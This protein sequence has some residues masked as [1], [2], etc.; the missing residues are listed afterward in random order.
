MPIISPDIGAFYL[1]DDIP[2]LTD[3]PN[4]SLL[5]GVTFS[6]SG[7]G[8]DRTVSESEFQYQG[9]TLVNN[10]GFGVNVFDEDSEQFESFDSWV[11]HNQADG[12]PGTQLNVIGINQA[13]VIFT[14]TG[15]TTSLVNMWIVQLTD[16]TTFMVPDHPSTGGPQD[17]QNA[18]G[19][20]PIGNFEITS[21]EIVGV[22]TQTD[23]FTPPK[24]TYINNGL[25]GAPPDGV[26]DGE[27][28]A[29]DMNLGYDDS[30]GPTDGGGDQIT[31]GDDTIEGNGGNDTINGSSGNDLISGGDDND[32]IIGGD[33]NDTL[34]GDAG[35][36]TL[37]GSDGDDEINGGIGDDLLRPGSGSDTVNGGAGNDTL[38]LSSND[39]MDGGDDIDTLDAT[40]GNFGE[41]VSFNPDDSGL[42]DNGTTFQNIEV[43][44]SDGGSDNYDASA[45]TGDLTISTGADNDTIVGGQ[46]N[47]T[48][49]GGAD[50]DNIDGGAG[51]DVVYGGSGNDTLSSDGENDSLFGGDDAD[52]FIGTGF[53]PTSVGSFAVDGGSGGNDNDTLD[54]SGYEAQGFFVSDLVQNPETNGNP[55]FDGAVTLTNPTT[56]EV[57]VINFTDIENLILPPN[58]PDGIVDGEETGEVMDVGYDDSNGPNDDGGDLI[59]NGADIIEGNGG[60]DT[61]TAGGGNDT[62]DGGADDDSIDGGLGDDSLLGGSGSDTLTG[63]A[64]QDDLLGDAGDDDIAVGG[65]DTGIGGSGDDVFTIDATDTEPDVDITIDGGTDGT[66]G[67]PDDTANGD[68]G[69][70]LDL[71]DQTDDLDVV[72]D[73]DPES[74]TVD[75]LDADGTPDIKFDEIEKILTGSGADTVDGGTST[76][77]IDVDTG[78]GDD[79]VTGGSGGDTIAAGTGD[80]VVDGGAGDDDITGGAGTDTLTGGLGA[81]TLDGGGDDDDLITGV[82]DTALGGDGDDV[83]TFDPTLDEGPGVITVFG[84]EGDEGGTDTSNDNYPGAS[85]PNGD[86][87]DLTG[88]NVV[89]YNPD[90]GDPSSESGSI[91]VLN[92]EGDEI[93]I[94]Y[95]EIETVIP[96]FT[97]GTL[98]AT[99]KGQCLVEDLKPGDRIITR[100][101]GFQEIAWV[102]A[103]KVPGLEM[104][105]QPNLKPVMVKAGALGGG[106]PERDMLLSPN[107]KV[108]LADFK[109]ELYFEEREV[110]VAAK[111]LVGMPG[112]ERVNVT[113]TTYIHFMFDRHEVVLSDG[114]WTESYHPGDYSINGID[115]GARNEILALFPELATED[116][117]KDYRLART[118]LKKHEARI[119]FG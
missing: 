85:G 64:G 19:G 101:N 103:K 24:E 119:L 76:G 50:N 34:F 75:G 51:T 20:Q 47:D 74:G 56:S 42:T 7:V 58:A 28:F 83:F 100:D 89:S 3:G 44:E 110:F 77:P 26:V 61:I 78:A 116:G 67:N 55:G 25:A 88:L 52:T 63:G 72:L 90:G 1:G 2:E 22:N 43:F 87:L 70:I 113:Q 30:N 21:F 12:S 94:N 6:S 68:D 59:T 117:L 8:T 80:D 84:G 60:D 13:Q 73:A 36:D 53:S 18:V 107:H 45:A 35:N 27:D 99:A 41:T 23:L 14:T 69:D 33:D 96:C 38:E 31:G 29:E 98:I 111:H 46:G 71:S 15:G 57:L 11:V 66:D 108:L 4:N 106:L 93:T 104:V 118:E 112:I 54:L 49:D 65:G 109:A 82:G 16:G 37:L 5:D 91:V 102:G 10:P 81:D 40:F 105:K 39:V 48:L 62:V 32:S 17:Y 114:A 9:E 79:S 97:P 86:V 95:S 92:D 115:E